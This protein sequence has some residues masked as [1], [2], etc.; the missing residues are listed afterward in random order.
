MESVGLASMMGDGWMDGG[1]YRN[2]DLN[3]I[4]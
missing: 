3:R 1:V 4:G 2:S